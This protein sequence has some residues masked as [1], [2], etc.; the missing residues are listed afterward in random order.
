MADPSDDESSVSTA[1]DSSGPTVDGSSPPAASDS[2]GPTPIRPTLTR[3]LVG[4]LQWAITASYLF[5]L[6]LL[7][8]VW[9]LQITRR[10]IALDLTRAFGVLVLAAFVAG[11]LWVGSR[12]SAPGAHARRIEAVVTLLV[13]GFLFPFAVPRLLTLL[14]V[15]LPVPL[16]GFGLAYA[17]ALACSYGLVYGLGVRFFLGADPEGIREP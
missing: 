2:P 7:V 8:A 15:A 6:G 11:Y 14:G 4:G 16:F 10:A 13:L 5:L 17:L 12:P 3:K 1:D 9:Y